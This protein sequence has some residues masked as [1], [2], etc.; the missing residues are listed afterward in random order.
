MWPVLANARDIKKES[1]REVREKQ[2]YIYFSISYKSSEQT[3][4]LVIFSVFLVRFILHFF[5][6]TIEHQ[7]RWH[8]I[9]DGDYFVSEKDIQ[10]RK[11]HL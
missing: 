7:S 9:L 5:V 4:Q 8:G 1:G 2:Y 10:F 6:R 3:V 11:S